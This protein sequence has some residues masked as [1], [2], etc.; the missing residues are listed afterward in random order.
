MRHAVFLV[1][2]ERHGVP[3]PAIPS[4]AGALPDLR[5]PIGPLEE[6][7][8]NRGISHVPICLRPAGDANPRTHPSR[9]RPLHAARKAGGVPSRIRQRGCGMLT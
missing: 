9:S 8:K 7:I 6:R 1:S 5:P 3:R 4:T 2:L